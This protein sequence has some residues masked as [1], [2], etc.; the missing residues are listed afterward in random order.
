MQLEKPGTEKIRK[1]RD[2][3]EMQA[4]M[5]VFAEPRINY[6]TPSHCTFSAQYTHLNCMNLL[7]LPP[8]IAM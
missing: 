1:A 2:D 3:R 4:L 8:R 7:L 6:K 5:Q